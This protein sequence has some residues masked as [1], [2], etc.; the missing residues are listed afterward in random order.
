MCRG[1]PRAMDPGM[2]PDPLLRVEALSK[3]YFRSRF[4]RAAASDATPAAF[5]DLTFSLGRGELLGLVG[6]SGAGKSTLARALALVEPPDSGQVL[7]EGHDLWAGTGR[8]RAGWRARIQ[9]IPQQPAASLNPRF[10]AAEIVSE[11]LVVQR[12]GNRAD[13]RRMAA[14]W[15]ERA[16]LDPGSLD[17]RALEFSGGER[18][19]LAIARALILEPALVILDESFAGLDLSVQGQIARLIG[20]LRRDRGLTCILI[21][22]DL[23][24]AA[25]MAD[26]IAVMDAGRI[27]ESGRASL[28]VAHPRQARTREL[29]DAAMAL[30]L[31]EPA[32]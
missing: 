31:A 1:F 4:F 18:Q 14:K 12:R 11:P 13:Q 7:F 15:M 30:S 25:A 27:V 28:L 21:T 16:G 22:H 32:P 24:L 3:R 9:L 2:P 29:L 8:E 5:E 6:A 26:E 10:T 19:R 17:R 20:E 23:A